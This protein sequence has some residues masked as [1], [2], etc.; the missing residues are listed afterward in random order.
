[1]SARYLP[2]AA[3]AQARKALD[4]VFDGLNPFDLPFKAAVPQRLILYPADGYELSESAWS[5]LT[6]AARAVGESS[7]YYASVEGADLRTL[8]EVWEVALSAEGLGWFEASASDGSRNPIVESALWSTRGNWGLLISHEHHVVVGGTFEFMA[9]F[10]ARVPS[11]DE[12]VK[13]FIGDIAHYA[14]D[15]EPVPPWLIRLLN[16]VYGEAR[17][18]RLVAASEI[19]P[20]PNDSDVLP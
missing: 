8:R 17:A 7:V 13:A 6:T 3:L 20:E 2:P 11:A 10:Q 12:Q 18:D 9:Q 15:S 16:H 14:D 4:A 19:Y 1:M 5:A